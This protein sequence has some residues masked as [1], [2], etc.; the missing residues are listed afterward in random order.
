MKVGDKVRIIKGDYRNAEGT[1]SSIYGDTIA[2]QPNENADT[3]C[4]HPSHVKVIEHFKDELPKTQYQTDEYREGTSAR[5]RKRYKRADVKAQE[6]VRRRTPQQRYVKARYDAGRRSSGAKEFSLTFDEYFDIISRPCRYCNSD[7]SQG[8][9]S[10]LDRIDN[11]KGYILG[12]VSPCCADC[13][14]RRAKTM[15]ADE[16]E[17]QS[18]INGFW[19]N[20]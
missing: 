2:V 13:N 20:A 9:G 12:N 10:G 17:R 8:A 5:L 4:F 14:R 3:R 1:I 11:D 7:I 19:K 16:F 15:D 6:Y 18:K